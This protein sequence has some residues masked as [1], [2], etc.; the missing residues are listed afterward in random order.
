MYQEQ[1]L[2]FQYQQRFQWHG[3]YRSYKVLRWVYLLSHHQ[4]LLLQIKNQLLTHNHDLLNCLEIYQQITIH[5]SKRKIAEK[6]KIKFNF[7]E[8]EKANIDPNWAMEN[9]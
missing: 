6:Q 3:V 8:I 7:V 1:Q 9:N 5:L 4:H 2:L